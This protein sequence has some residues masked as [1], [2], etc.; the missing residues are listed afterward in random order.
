MPAPID[1]ALPPAAL[2]LVPI[3]T[4][5]AVLATALAPI[6]VVPLAVTPLEDVIRNTVRESA[7]FTALLA[8]FG[9]IALGLGLLGVYGVL[10]YAVSQRRREIGMRI[11]LGATSGN[12]TLVVA[13]AAAMFVVPGLL[14]GVAITM[15]AG[16]FI[17]AQLFG[18]RASDPLIMGGV[19]LLMTICAS[20]AV[21]IPAWKAATIDP[22]TALRVD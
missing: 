21:A 6:A 15:A 12:V 1:T 9:V 20:A 22:T 2:A 13:R 19:G 4:A 7:V 5:S 10:A 3:A 8:G 14:V 18:V 16:K 17:E 11:A